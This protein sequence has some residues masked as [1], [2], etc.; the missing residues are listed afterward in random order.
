MNWFEL[1]YKFL[2]GLGIFFYGMKF[3]SE[4]LQSIAGPLIK[5]II[6]TLTT[7]R[8]LAV[9]VG[10]FVTT[11]VQSSSVTTVMVVSLVNAGLMELTQAIGVILGANIGTTITGWIIAIKVGKYGLLFVALGFSPM[12]FSSNESIKQMGKILV[13]LG[14]VFMGLNFMSG[15][16]KPLRTDASFMHVMQ[17]F[18]ANNLWS[19]LACI[20]LGT[21]LTFIIQSSS[22]MLGVTIALAVTGAISFQT[23][24]GLVLG[25]NIGTTITALLASV[26]ANTEGKRAARA[27][28]IFNVLG[29]CAI[30]PFFWWYVD[31]IDWLIVSDVAQTGADGSYV[32]VAAHIAAAHTIF[33]VTNV[34]LFLPFLPTLAK[35]VSWLTPQKTVIEASNLRYLSSDVEL[36]PSL[37]LVAAE[38]EL[39]VFSNLV[40]RTLRRTQEYLLSDE[41]EEK[42][43]QRINQF[44]D[45]AD[46]IQRD[47]TVYLCRTQQSILSYEESSH[48]HS[49]IRVADE[50]ES[51]TDYCASLVRYKDRMTKASDKISPDGYS[52]LKQYLEK[53]LSYYNEIHLSLST[54]KPWE[55]DKLHVELDNLIQFANKIRK[56]HENR[57]QNGKCAPIIGMIFSDIVIGLRK[58]NGHTINVAETMTIKT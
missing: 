21:F 6:N 51:I 8:L 55:I 18:A 25:E 2:G 4:G 49:L 28:G 20:G 46:I 23:G 58:I 56:G 24:V 54:N 11:I 44:E 57:L 26:G 19:L 41:P 16:F 30:I 14:F 47:I 7:N 13:A 33:N 5:R 52:E 35:F 38:K 12:L 10:A 53:V 1:A 42:I 17:F 48:L 9:A 50:L 34:C 15:A 45:K 31:F 27:H 22:A 36:S 32:N 40:V 39:G 37:A 43:A 3:L 29:V